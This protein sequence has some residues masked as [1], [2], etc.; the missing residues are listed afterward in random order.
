MAI[1]RYWAVRIVV[2]W[3]IDAEIPS[4]KEKNRSATDWLF[5]CLTAGAVEEMKFFGDERCVFMAFGAS[6][7]MACRLIIFPQSLLYSAAEKKTKKNNWLY[8]HSTQQQLTHTHHDEFR[9][10]ASALNNKK[11][12]TSRDFHGL[13]RLSCI[14]RS[15]HP[16]ACSVCMYI[17]WGRDEYNNYRQSE[18]GYRENIFQLGIIASKKS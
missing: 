18:R 1:F 5:I 16:H 15:I 12:K 6:G 10:C 7:R 4:Q 17:Q 9:A 2:S 8:I 11:K 13:A 14:Y 3:T